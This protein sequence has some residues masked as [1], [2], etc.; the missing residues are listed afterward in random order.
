MAKPRFRD[1]KQGKIEKMK[2]LR[3]KRVERERGLIIPQKVIDFKAFIR[4]RFYGTYADN[5]SRGGT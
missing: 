3:P 1:V 2:R 5:P 4:D